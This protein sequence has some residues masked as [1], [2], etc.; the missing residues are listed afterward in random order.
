[1][2]AAG[3]SY[4]ARCPIRQVTNAYGIR[5]MPTNRYDDSDPVARMRSQRVYRQ[6]DGW[7]FD[8]REGPQFGPFAHQREAEN[9]LAVFVAQ[10]AHERPNDG[11]ANVMSPGS[12]DGID[13]MVREV[14]D[15]LRCH[16]DYGVRAAQT[17]AASRLDELERAGG[18]DFVS[19][20]CRRILQY[21]IAHSDQVF[22]FDAFLAGRA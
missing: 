11:S 15:V 12:Q 5:R 16:R 19:V 8:S 3:F 4:R 7:Y 20:E 14:S 9:A 18:D 1:M 10:H 22:D 13:H 21:V 17:W 6:Q 2:P